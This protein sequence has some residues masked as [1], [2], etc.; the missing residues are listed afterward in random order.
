MLCA[1]TAGLLALVALRAE[2]ADTREAI[3]GQAKRVYH[4]TRLA[5]A[6]PV[7]DGRLDDACWTGAGEWSGDYTQQEPDEGEPASQATQLKIVYDDHYLYVAIR[8]FDSDLAAVP[9]LRGKRDEFTG[10]MVGITFDSY[11]DRRTAFEFDVTSGGSKIDL[12][13]R[14]LMVDTTWNAVWD[15]RVGFEDGAWTAEYRIP[16]SQLR[17]ARQPGQVWGLHSW[18]WIKRRQEESDWNPIP[19]DNSGMVYEFGELRG[20]EELPRARRIELLPYVVARTTTTPRAATTPGRTRRDS[21]LD[22]GLD[23]KLG[24]ASDFTLDLTINPDFGQVELD[25]SEINL[26][27]Y[28]TFFEERRPFFVEGKD[29]FAWEIGDDQLFY[30]RRVGQAPSFTPATSG[31]LE[32]PA[33]TR[34]RGAAKFAGKTSRGLAIGALYAQSA[35]AKA[36]II[37]N[38]GERTELVEPATQFMVARLQQEFAGGRTTLGGVAT[39]TLRSLAATEPAAAVLPERALTGGI[40]LHHFWDRRDFELLVKATGSRVE[41]TSAAIQRLMKD[42]VHDFERSDARHL[43]VRTDATSLSGH[44]GRMRLGRVGGGRWR[45]YGNYDWRSPGFEL[46]DLGYLAEADRQQFVGGIDYVVT[47][48]GPVVR[49]YEAHAAQ[50]EDYDF[51]GTH[52]GRRTELWGQVRLNN[53]WTFEPGISADHGM[54]DTHMLRGGPSFLVPSETIA[55]LRVESPGTETWRWHALVEGHA[56]HAGGSH[57][58]VIKAGFTWR[59]LGMLSV[60]PELTYE[61][62][63]IDHQYAGTSVAAPG[64]AARYLLGRMHQHT[65]ASTLQVD[66]NVSPTVSLSWYGSLFASSGDFARFKRV[67]DPLAARYGDRFTRLDGFVTPDATGDQLVVNEGGTIYS[68]ANPDFD[69]RELKS[70]LVLRWEYREGSTLYLV[71]TQYRVNTDRRRG[72]SA[73]EEYRRLLGTPA[74]NTLLL[75][76]S[77][78]FS[79]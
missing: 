57:R 48:P 13:I 52:L 5:D 56:F 60:E 39:G 53:D 37:E 69:L 41:G 66:A 55:N 77:Y 68:W 30:S 23:A 26:T 18:R 35:G 6:S 50:H 47:Q 20:I 7:I 34:I 28:E 24:I 65:L 33:A 15:V 2:A 17:Y 63:H 45:Y 31:Q 21:S 19:I 40:D 44:G 10:D 27:T 62:G 49:S 1:I 36:R 9:H 46:N 14:D 12:Q 38:D 71:W 73:T 78:W 76:V 51:G 43:A 8:A 4:A 72:F 3:A 79:Q 70:N 25:P 74:E 32:L 59:A 61:R 75:K 22:A 16:F 58:H 29:V 42:P 11:H 64:N 54:R 67:T